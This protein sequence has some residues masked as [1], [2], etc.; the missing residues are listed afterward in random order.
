M[1]QEIMADIQSKTA[2]TESMNRGAIAMQLR[3]VAV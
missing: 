3:D 1:E 2:T